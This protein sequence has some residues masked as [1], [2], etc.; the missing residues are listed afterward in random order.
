MESRSLVYNKSKSFAVK[1]VRLYQ[2]LSD[3]KHDYVL[4]KQILKAGTSIGANIAEAQS[5]ISR[6]DF[7][8]KLYIALKE[9]SET[10]FWLELLYNTDYISKELF[11]DLSHDC[12]ELL[13][14]LTSITKTLNQTP[15]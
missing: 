14:L 2:D 1:I 6:G 9:A 8:A 13:K 10:S 3:K 5:G 7:K 4:S 12:T 11:E 15:E